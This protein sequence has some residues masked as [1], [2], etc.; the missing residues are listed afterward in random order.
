M[1]TSPFVARDNATRDK[2]GEKKQAGRKRAKTE[3]TV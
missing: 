2:R 3:Y 1:G